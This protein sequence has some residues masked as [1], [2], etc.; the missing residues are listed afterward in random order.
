MA[1]DDVVS[2]V[3]GALIDYSAWAQG[4]DTGLQKQAHALYTAIDALQASAPDP[5]YL[6]IGAGDYVSNGVFNHALRDQ[7][8]DQWVGQVGQ[9]FLRIETSGLPPGLVHGNY[10]DFLNGLVT[11]SQADLTKLVGPDPAGDPPPLPA[12]PHD[13][14]AWW[15]AL[16][17]D[18]QEAYLRYDAADVAWLAT[19]DQ[20]HQA[21]FE[22]LQDVYVQQS[23]IDAGI[24]PR[25]WDP[26]KGLRANDAII[27]K[28]YNYY[29]H[30]WDQNH[31]LQWAGMAKLAGASLYAG[32]QDL[33]AVANQEGNFWTH[34]TAD[35]PSFLLGGLFGVGASEAAQ[36]EVHS[37]AQWFETEFLKM[38]K[39]VFL[40]QGWQHAAY[41]HGGMDAITALH[42]ENTTNSPNSMD[43]V[44]Y[45]AWQ[46]IDSGDPARVQQGNTALLWREQH[47]TLQP[48]FD[49]TRNHHGPVGSVFTYALSH[50]SDSPIPGGKPF[51]EVSG[52]NI[53]EFQDRWDWITRDMMPKYQQLLHDDPQLAW[54]LVDTPVA[55]R[56]ELFR[57]LG[58]LGN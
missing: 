53:T 9:A 48:L 26:S 55:E 7:R 54:Q 51:S 30:V 15:A 13:R 10:Q 23:F 2:A 19:E 14:G 3:P 31:S 45:R 4:L 50:M 46:D 6:T 34:L 49:E 28:L 43:D 20:L 24:D 35:V 52:G 47:K 27:Q 36:A 12:N 44:T 17:V 38:A 29:G 39:N 18:E 40:D 37:E 58:F 11:V 22:N 57:K 5:R 1:G 16:T 25:A 33:D 21:G 56:A 42:D 32:F 41:L 8:T